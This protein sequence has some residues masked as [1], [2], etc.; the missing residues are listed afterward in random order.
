MTHPKT[1][2]PPCSPGPA[3]RRAGLCR[4]L[5]QHDD[6][7]GAFIRVQCRLACL[8]ADHPET[9]QLEETEHAL[10]AEYESEWIGDLAGLVEWC[11]FRRGF[12]EE[13]ALTSEQF[14]E[15]APLLFARAP[16][17]EVHLSRVRDRLGSIASSTFLEKPSYLDLSSNPVRDY[18]AKTLAESPYLAQ[19]RGLNLSSS[20]IGDSGLASRRLTHSTACAS[21]TSTTTAS[22]TRASATSPSR[23]SPGSSAAYLRFNAIPAPDGASLLQRRAGIPRAPLTELT[24][25]DTDSTG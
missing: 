13:V 7:L 9:L 16:I 24:T 1:S 25:D 6:P 5:D 18:G 12:V 8:G 11:G 19:V 14:L 2:S 23:P 22:A 20:G 3:M 21:F 10:L 17:Q 15:Y 4:W